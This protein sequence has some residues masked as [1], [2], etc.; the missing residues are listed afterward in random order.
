MRLKRITAIAAIAVLAFGVA[1]CGKKEEPAASSKFAAGSTMDTIAKAGKLTIGIKYDQPLFGL[2]GLDGKFTGFDVEIGKILAAELGI[3]EN[4]IKFEESVTKARED[5]IVH[6]RVDLV[7]ATYTINDARKQKV[8]FAGPYYTAGQDILV[9]KGDTSITG[10][11]TFK[12][13]TKKV[14]SVTGSTPAKNIKTYLKDPATQLVEFDVYTKCLDALKK[15]T[16]DAVTTDNVILMGYVDKEPDAYTLLG[17]PFTKEP[18]GIGVKK[19]DKV[20]R[21]WVNDMLEKA[22]ADGRYKK[23]WEATGSAGKVAPVPTAITVNR[24]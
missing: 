3:A 7:I 13:G 6:G 19:D 12:E 2:K 8:S 18:Y 24:Y 9:A 14:C 11:D 4:K 1:A 22:F 10:P 23:A 16:V 5:H 20:F 17:K 21:D 15:K